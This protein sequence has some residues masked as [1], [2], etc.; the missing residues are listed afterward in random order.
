MQQLGPN[1]LAKLKDL[2][3]KA[4]AIVEEN[5]DEDDDVPELVDDVNIKED[6]TQE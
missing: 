1:Q 6:N 3:Q 2:G 5:E 4:G